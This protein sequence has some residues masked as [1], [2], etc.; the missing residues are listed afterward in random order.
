MTAKLIEERQTEALRRAEREFAGPYGLL[1][2]ALRNAEEHLR[3]YGLGAA[4]GHSSSLGTDSQDLILLEAARLVAR[5]PNGC[6]ERFA[7]LLRAFQDET[8]RAQHARAI[9]ARE[10]WDEQKLVEV[11]PK[12]WAERSEETAREIVR[13]GRREV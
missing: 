8:D 6:R 13:T 7:N 3:T 10:T 5:N 12:H 1:N 11:V 9:L 2:A 4:T